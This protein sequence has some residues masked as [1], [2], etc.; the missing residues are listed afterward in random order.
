MIRTWMW[1]LFVL[2]FISTVTVSLAE[3]SAPIPIMEYL[4]N[5]TGTVAKNTGSANLP[6]L[7]LRDGNNNPFDLHTA[8]GEG[9]SGQPDD[10]A[11][12]PKLAIP[13]NGRATQGV[14]DDDVDGP[15][16]KGLTIILSY[17][18]ESL[19]EQGSSTFHNLERDSEGNGKYGYRLQGNFDGSFTLFLNNK[20]I[21]SGKG[22][23]ETG[24]WVTI[25]AVYDANGS[26]N[27]FKCVNGVLTLV[28]THST[29]QLAILNDNVPFS[30]GSSVLCLLDNIIL[31]PVPLTESEISN[32]LG[33]SV[34]PPPPPPEEDKLFVTATEPKDKQENVRV[35]LGGRGIIITFNQSIRGDVI[36]GINH[37]SLK[38]I[39]RDNLGNITYY[40]PDIL[41]SYVAKD[42]T[43]VFTPDEKLEYKKE[44]RCSVTELITAANFAGTAC[45]PEVITFKTESAVPPPPTPTP[46]ESPTPETTPSPEPTPEIT[47]SPEPTVF[48]SPIPSPTITSEPTPT[49]PPPPPPTPTPVISPEPTIS[50]VPSPVAKG[51][52]FGK[53]ISDIE[54]K[55]LKHVEVYLNGD[56]GFKQTTETDS[57]GNFELSELP[58]GKFSLRFTST[59]EDYKDTFM[60]VK[61]ATGEE[62]DLGSVILNRITLKVHVY[63][64]LR[65]ESDTIIRIPI[66]DAHLSL[67]IKI[68]T[69]TGYR[70]KTIKA[71]DTNSNGFYGFTELAPGRYKLKCR[72]KGYNSASKYVQMLDIDGD[73]KA[74]EPDE[75]KEF[76]LIE[77]E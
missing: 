30:I 44:Y 37:L 56:D 61:L 31:F 62:K 15:V 11:Y 33:C 47:P 27:F 21:T 38:E 23:T 26:V 74:D 40:G 65:D 34:P 59:S 42:K 24:V 50:P 25:I 76:F 63:H 49:P 12:N 6:D 69:T 35:D 1:I 55:P 53:V 16:L 46:E 51:A 58:E 36:Y 28:S 45:E 8:G 17:K 39:K 52:I 68:K 4:F 18:A 29:D 32:V 10:S 2:G 75:Q 3:D 43:L 57:G 67:K 13:P 70:W 20:T 22:Y 7:Q 60:S 72:A 48:P 64:E 9:F 54:D 5:E 41:G 14:D 73:G 71:G 66:E 19:E 77:R